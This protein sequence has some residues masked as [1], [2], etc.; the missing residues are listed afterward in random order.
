MHL[1]ENSLG[2]EWIQ[3]A[4]ISPGMAVTT[5]QIFAYFY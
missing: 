1:N 4:A 3:L 2:M 5:S